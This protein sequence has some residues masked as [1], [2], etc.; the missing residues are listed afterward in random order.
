ML[1]VCCS[2]IERG[3]ERGQGYP[4]PLRVRFLSHPEDLESIFLRNVG[5]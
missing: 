3:G 5:I 1:I 2:V 4:E